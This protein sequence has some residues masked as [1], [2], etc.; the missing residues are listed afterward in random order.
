M[1]SVFLSPITSPIPLLEPSV[2]GPELVAPQADGFFD[3]GCPVPWR[4]S[5]TSGLYPQC[6]C[7][8]PELEQLKISSEVPKSLVGRGNR[9]KLHQWKLLT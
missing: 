6:P 2:S 8:T 5:E 1:P 7:Y 3:G 9:K 4:I